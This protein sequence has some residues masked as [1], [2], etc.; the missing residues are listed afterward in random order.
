MKRALLI[1]AL[2]LAGA[3]AQTE[4]QHQLELAEASCAM[5]ARCGLLEVIGYD[6]AI[7]C[8]DEIHTA[9]MDSAAV[10]GECVEFN[11]T[12]S[13]ECIDGIEAMSCDE[14]FNFPSACDEV[15]Q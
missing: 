8:K 3:C 1:P 6:D 10:E 12:A 13:A 2:L 11:A 4:E 14:E 15:C 9:A 5:W 7:D